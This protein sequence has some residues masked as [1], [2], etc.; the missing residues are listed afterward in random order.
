M[1][2]STI[3]FGQ[4]LPS[5]P[6]SRA[7]AESNKADVHVVLGS[8]LTVSPAC[9]C[10]EQT[11]KRG[12]KLVIV[13]LQQTPLTPLA[14]LHIHAST[15]TV[16]EM[17]MQR[18]AVPI[19][20]FRLER[21][22]LFGQEGE[23]VFATAVDIHVPEVEIGVL[24]GVD[25]RGRVKGILESQRTKAIWEHV[26]HRHAAADLDLSALRP[27]LHFVGHYLEPPLTLEVDLA[28]GGKDVRLAFDPVDRSWSV[29]AMGRTEE[30]QQPIVDRDREYGDAHREYVVKMRR[31][32][33]SANAEE[34]VE[35]EFR[36]ARQRIEGFLH[37]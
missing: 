13:N 32:Q 33:G 11:A 17:L 22:I 20:P 28:D 15:D 31:K 36:E 10:P 3:D 16:M 9:N 25:W 23:E 19:P 37:S 5:E 21:R 24:C 2:N 7:M 1:L 4:S 18:L 6:L 14:A 34:E 27:T 30:S 35:R 29:E 26:A 12:G 8:S